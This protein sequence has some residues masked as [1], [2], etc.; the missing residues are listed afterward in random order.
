[1]SIPTP[2]SSYS[3][4]EQ[5]PG[6][7]QAI[8]LN[9][10]GDAWG[11]TR[12]AGSGGPIYAAEA[13]QRLV[14]L[15][16]GRAAEEVLLGEPSA[17]AGGGADRDLALATKWAVTASAALGSDSATGLVWLGVPDAMNLLRMLMDDALAARVRAIL[18][19]AYADALALVRRRRAA[20]E[21]LA[22]ALLE[23]RALDGA[24]PG[25]ARSGGGGVTGRGLFYGSQCGGWRWRL[26]A[27]KGLRP[28]REDSV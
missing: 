23:R 25:V 11:A 12:S 13:H 19:A 7:L 21:G 24:D 18:D 6:A 4:C 3:L 22:A 9:A 14:V 2:F 5:R 17:G 28:R 1:V 15:M 16:A 26:R 20:L 8:T 10:S 27:C